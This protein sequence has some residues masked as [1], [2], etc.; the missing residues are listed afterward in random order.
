MRAFVFWVD[1]VFGRIRTNRGAVLS[2][3]VLLLVTVRPVHGQTSSILAKNAVVVL[4]EQGLRARA[5]EIADIYPGIRKELEKIFKWPVAFEPTVLLVHDEETFQRMAGTDLV[6]AFALPE[7]NAMVIDHS[8]MTRDPFTI[9]ATLKHELCHLLLHHYIRDDRLPKWL[10]EGVAQWV[11]GGLAEIMP[12]HGRA[13]LD[14][15]VLAGRTISMRALTRR[16]PRGK[17]GLLLAYEESRSFVDYMIEHYGTAGILSVLD[18]LR[19]GEMADEALRKGLSISL[20]ELEN[21]WLQTLKK[22]VTWFTYLAHH[23]YEVLFFIG[24]LITILAFVRA[25]MKKRAYLR[26]GEED[27]PER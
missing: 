12:D 10:D 5:E 3:I 4:F 11:S 8:K 1:A 7:K 2:C 25:F 15:A 14:G 23:L 17:K 9:E 18:H 26:Q 6:V 22:R 20:D 13:F 16:F 27:S 19:Q 24:A 21:R